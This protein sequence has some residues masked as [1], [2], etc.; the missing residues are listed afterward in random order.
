MVYFLIFFM[1]CSEMALSIVYFD[2]LLEIVRQSEELKK[3][4]YGIAKQVGC[5]SVGTAV[6]GVF[7]GP[8]G[9]LL[10]GMA[11]IL[12]CDAA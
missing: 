8:A 12:Q 11:G 6:G 7:G 3:T 4:T 5:V 2:K 10:G 1:F 9:A